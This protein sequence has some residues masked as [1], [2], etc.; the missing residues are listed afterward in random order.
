MEYD[1][2]ANANGHM[3]PMCWLY[4]SKSGYVYLK[5]GQQCNEYIHGVF[6]TI[7]YWQYSV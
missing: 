2:D 3:I 1:D 7:I 4:N 6:A 5:K